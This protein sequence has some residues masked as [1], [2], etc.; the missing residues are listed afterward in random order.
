MSDPVHPSIT[1]T[2]DLSLKGAELIGPNTNSVSTSILHPDQYQLS[3]D[4]GRTE[5]GN[6]ATSR[7]SWLPGQLVGEN[8]KLKD[9]DTF[10]KTGLK[11]IYIRD[12]YAVGFA[13]SDRAWLTI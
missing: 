4:N 8:R 1:F 11:A 12:L 5:A 2:V 13:P 10:T 6:R 7:S 9:G 3:S